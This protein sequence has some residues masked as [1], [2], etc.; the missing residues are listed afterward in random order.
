MTFFIL[1]IVLAVVVLYFTPTAPVR[2]SSLLRRL[3]IEGSTMVIGSLYLAYWLRSMDDQRI[4]V[5]SVLAQAAIIL[6]GVT[7]IL[8]LKNVTVYFMRRGR[9]QN[10]K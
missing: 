4:N 9:E 6:A 5:G 7:L 3:A 10:R 2:R 1:S 8:T